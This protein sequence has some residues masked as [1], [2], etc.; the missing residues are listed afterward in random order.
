MPHQVLQHA[1]MASLIEREMIGVEQ[2]KAH[3]G[4][5][6]SLDSPRMRCA[7]CRIAFAAILFDRFPPFVRQVVLREPTGM[8]WVGELHRQS[9]GQDPSSGLQALLNGV[10]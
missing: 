1:S 7:V 3:E 4:T 9:Q 5:S 8:G 6:S 10:R 2:V